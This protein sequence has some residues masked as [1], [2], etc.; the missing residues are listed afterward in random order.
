MTEAQVFRTVMQIKEKAS[1]RL[2]RTL[3]YGEGV[4]QHLTLSCALCGTRRIS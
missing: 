1:N 4:A 2:S 3:R